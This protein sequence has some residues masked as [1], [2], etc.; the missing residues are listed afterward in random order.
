MK[1]LSR[2]ERNAMLF[3]ADFETSI[4]QTM[5]AFYGMIGQIIISIDGGITYNEKRDLN[6]IMDTSKGFA[7]D[8]DITGNKWSLLND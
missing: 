4:L 8:H 5:V 7:A 1:M 2:A 6:I 3:G